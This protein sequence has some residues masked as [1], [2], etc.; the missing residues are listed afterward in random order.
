MFW[1]SQRMFVMWQENSRGLH[2]FII[3]NH[4]PSW[5]GVTEQL[6]MKVVSN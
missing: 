4:L 3:Y 1:Y 2:V 5:K 6:S